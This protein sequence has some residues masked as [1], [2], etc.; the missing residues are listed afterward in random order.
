MT[1]GLYTI[2][3]IAG[4]QTFLIVINNTDVLFSVASTTPVAI[5][6]HFY[7]VPDLWALCQARGC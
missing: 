3:E 7:Q 5:R 1:C 4:Q 6:V 2:S